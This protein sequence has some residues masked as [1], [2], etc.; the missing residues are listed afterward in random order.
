[1]R[2]VIITGLIIIFAAPA[3]LLAQAFLRVPH[4]VSDL[5]VAIALVDDGGT[6]EL[7]P[8][9]WTQPTL[10]ITNKS[11]TVR[12]YAGPEA[13]ALRAPL[14]SPVVSFLGSGP[15]SLTLEGLRIDQG[16]CAVS[17]VTV[18][19]ARLVCISCFFE[20]NVCL[21]EGG[22]IS[23]LAVNHNAQLVLQ[24]C[25]LF[26]NYAGVGGG[27]INLEALDAD[28]IVAATIASTLVAANTSTTGAAISGDNGGI[29]QVALTN[30]TF[31]YNQAAL[32]SGLIH[33]VSEENRPAIISGINAIMREN[34]PAVVTESMGSLAGATFAT[35]LVLS[36]VE[37]GWNGLG[38][39]D[40]DP[41]FVN[42]LGGDFRLQPTSPCIDTGG[43][44]LALLPLDAA[45]GGRLHGQATD[46]GAYEF[47]P[48]DVRAGS[49]EGLEISANVYYTDGAAYPEVAEGDL[50]HVFA[51]PD[52]STI[53]GAPVL[54][55]GQIVLSGTPLASPVG[56]P[57]VHLDFGAPV[58]PVLLFDPFDLDVGG[59]LIGT[60]VQWGQ[61]M[62][63]GMAGHAFLVQAF[64]L[65]GASANGFFVASDALLL[66]V[67]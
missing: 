14:G 4:D 54:L 8:G 46:M 17:P 37:G 25:R 20:T 32:G 23:V 39:I 19:D 5:S 61:V 49:R 40:A 7:G 64:A 9:V 65:S 44:A 27:A 24:S 2:Q 31:A 59:N 34:E 55:A 30:V 47:R 57:E 50:V 18:Q 41:Q 42:P 26:G 62:P 51:T 10:Q 22:A 38:N 11:L 67:N 58:P 21:G 3:A 28:R 6:I 56:F 15:E 1:M 48:Y 45:G 63:A 13:T 12:G 29:L 53:D 60:T 66:E 35:D 52:A 43:A 36:N 16:Y 33:I